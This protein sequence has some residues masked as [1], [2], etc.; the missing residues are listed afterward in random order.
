[1]FRQNSGIWRSRSKHH[2][3]MMLIYAVKLKTSLNEALQVTDLP[4]LLL[5]QVE[6]FRDSPT[7]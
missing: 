3:S 1:M 2:L 6:L 5:A 7:A 4:R